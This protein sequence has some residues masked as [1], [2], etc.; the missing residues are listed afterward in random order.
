MVPRFN[1]S[2]IRSKEGHQALG[3]TTQGARGVWPSVVMEVGYSEALDFLRLDAKWWLINSVGSTQF[4]I[5]VQL[6]T[7]PFTIHIEC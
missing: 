1:L 4:V 6:M 2:D 3:P 7:D 5:I